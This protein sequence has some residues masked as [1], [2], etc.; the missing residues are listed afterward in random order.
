MKGMFGCDMK[1]QWINF[2]AYISGQ[3]TASH[4]DNDGS[5]GLRHGFRLCLS[6]LG[7]AAVSYT[8]L[9]LPTNRE[10]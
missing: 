7:I 8:H 4:A 2:S 1:M 9:T 6:V 5:G 3:T 10:V